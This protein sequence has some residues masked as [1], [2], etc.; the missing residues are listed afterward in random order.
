MLC[1]THLPQIAAMADKNFLISKCSSENETHT[2]V[3]ELTG[4]E[5]VSEI[6]RLSGGK[7]I[8]E[9][10]EA[11]ADEMKQWSERYKLGLM[12]DD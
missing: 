10:A 6:A 11:A 3:R 9:A 7:D 8:S 1:V 12:R 5:A 2:D 4:G